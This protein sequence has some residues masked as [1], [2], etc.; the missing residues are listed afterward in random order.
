GPV[1]G[2]VPELGEGGRLPGGDVTADGPQASAPASPK[3]TVQSARDTLQTT[4]TGATA[5]G[6][7]LQ[8]R[9]PE[10]P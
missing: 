2:N 5:P 10:A 6:S 9:A 8:S 7:G 3:A 4:A 1:G